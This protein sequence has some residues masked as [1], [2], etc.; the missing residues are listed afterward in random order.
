MPDAVIFDMDGVLIDSEPLHFESEYAALRKLGVHTADDYLHRFVGMTAQLLWARILAEQGIDK[1]V[2]EMVA[3]VLEEKLRLLRAGDF[4]PIDGVVELLDSLR[5]AGVP[6]GIASSSSRVFIEAVLE[7]LGIASYIRA[8]AS[9]EEVPRGKPYPDVYLE[10]ARL[11]GARPE[12][13][14][15][16][17][18]SRNGVLAAKAAGMRCVGFLNP[19]SGNQDLSAADRTV[20]S[21][22]ELSLEAV[23]ALA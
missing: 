8:F 19:L 7:K 21:L 2:D 20:R 9:G 10:A 22:R 6:V 17:E 13:C 23:A 14:L 16:V 15:V 1:D 4:R 12:Q 18:D 11:L 3:E 5:A